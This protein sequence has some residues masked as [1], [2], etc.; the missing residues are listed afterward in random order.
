MY[1]YSKAWRC[2][3]GFRWPSHHSRTIPSV[4]A[5]YLG[6]RQSYQLMKRR[7]KWRQW[8]LIHLPEKLW[9]WFWRGERK[10]AICWYVSATVCIYNRTQRI[11]GNELNWSRWDFKNILL[12][13]SIQEKRVLVLDSESFR[14]TDFDKQ[15]FYYI[16][17]SSIWI[18]D[19]TRYT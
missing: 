14:I 4:V 19:K 16:L 9:P 15:E 6:L 8:H 12:Y 2:H 13:R 11:K 5:N 7:L 10:E 17:K 1:I 3:T 18:K